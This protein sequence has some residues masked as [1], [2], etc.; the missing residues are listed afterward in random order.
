MA[1][2]IMYNANLSDNN[3]VLLNQYQ[4]AKWN[5]PLSPPGYG[6][7]EAQKAMDSGGG[8]SVFTTDYLARLSNSANIDL[9]ATSNMTLDFKGAALT[10]ASDKSFTIRANGGISSSSSGSISTS[11]TTTGG[12]IYRS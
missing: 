12:N 4:S 9:Y 11:R 7:S 3:I 6:Y 8:Y 10:L 1:E 5:I 2:I